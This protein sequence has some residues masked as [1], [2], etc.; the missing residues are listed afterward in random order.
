M[1]FNSAASSKSY[2]GGYEELEF[3]ES[4]YCLI[5]KYISFLKTDASRNRKGELHFIGSFS[6][7]ILK[8]QLEL[9]FCKRGP[10][11]KIC[12]KS[13][14]FGSGPKFYMKSRSSIDPA[15]SQLKNEGLDLFEFFPLV[16]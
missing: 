2:V 10:K 16:F 6:N 15:R 14:F 7:F 13:R 8:N 1:K 3:E 11:P 5:L 12:I 9:G 4:Q